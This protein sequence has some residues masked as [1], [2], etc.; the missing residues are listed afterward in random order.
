MKY[1]PACLPRWPF[2]HSVFHILISHVLVR[3]LSHSFCQQPWL[4]AL[5][6]TLERKIT[7][8][9]QQAATPEQQDLPGSHISSNP[10]AGWSAGFIAH[11]ESR[12]LQPLL[13]TAA[14]KAA[15]KNKQKWIYWEN[16][17]AIHCVFYALT[18]ILNLGMFV[19]T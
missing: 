11:R 16:Q 3:N 1:K 14:P 18:R 10:A 15:A 9:C 4:W 6:A 13:K 19:P 12:L 7:Q 2:Q 17:S 5:A 8:E